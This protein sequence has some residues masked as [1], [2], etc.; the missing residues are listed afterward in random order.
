MLATIALCP[1][2]FY[3]AV[4]LSA[5]HELPPTT[6]S[7]VVSPNLAALS[8][9][10]G[11]RSHRLAP[12]HPVAACARRPRHP[13]TQMGAREWVQVIDVHLRRCRSRRE[14]VDLCPPSKKAAAYALARAS[15][16][17]A[18]SPH[19]ARD[20]PLDIDPSPRPLA[21]SQMRP[22]P[23]LP[24]LSRCPVMRDFQNNQRIL[25]REGGGVRPGKRPLQVEELAVR[26]RGRCRPE[27]ATLVQSALVHALPRSTPPRQA[28]VWNGEDGEIMRVGFLCLGN[29]VRVNELADGRLHICVKMPLHSTL[30]P[31][32][33]GS[34]KMNTH[35]SPPSSRCR[36]RELV[37]S[38]PWRA[39]IGV[40]AVELPFSVLKTPHSAR[41]IP[42]DPWRQ[43]RKK[44]S[45]ESPKHGAKMC[46]NRDSRVK[47]NECGSRE[48]SSRPSARRME[49]E[50]GYKRPNLRPMDSESACLFDRTLTAYHHVHILHPH[51]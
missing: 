4:P 29:I 30:R 7:A 26:V 10:P 20:P 25:F 47:L 21:P 18:R 37:L 36:S 6:T 44:N 23:S 28:S 51:A 34:S 16:T 2:S 24:A 45:P 8:P 32:A 49:E 42:P 22:R 15:R 43:Q 40:N 33:V 35:L 13:R 17:R 12:T 9:A 48:S 5:C 50:E 3:I 11:S 41:A 38:R 31:R 39:Q 14:V 19:D 27:H 1:R 46:G